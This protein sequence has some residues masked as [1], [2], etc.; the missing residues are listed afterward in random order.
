M[1]ILEA[2]TK[3]PPTVHL[4]I[5]YPVRKEWSDHYQ[6]VVQECKRAVDTVIAFAEIWGFLGTAPVPIVPSE[7]S[8]LPTELKNLS[9]ELLNA[10]SELGKDA[11]AFGLA[12]DRV[13]EA[14]LPAKEGG[15]GVKDCVILEQSLG[16]TR[17]LRAQHLTHPCIFASSNTSDFAFA[18]TDRPHPILAPYFNNANTQLTYAVSLNAAVSNLKSSGWTP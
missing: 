6:V 16:L 18:K 11:E 13:I 8:I 5:G 7:S 2:A 4:V 14:K 10:A 1:E 12:I 9:E 17:A 3:K 15:R